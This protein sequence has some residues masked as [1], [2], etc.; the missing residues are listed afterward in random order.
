MGY[1][2]SSNI[3]NEYF[4]IELADNHIAGKIQPVNWKEHLNQSYRAQMRTL[5]ASSTVLITIVCSLVFGIACGYAVISSILRA[6]SHQS[7][8]AHA[9]SAT[10]V[11]AA[12][13]TR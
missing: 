8:K 11:I 4:C 5:L 10:Q 3:S 7:E 6:F 1:R 12:T 13:T 9:A 2:R